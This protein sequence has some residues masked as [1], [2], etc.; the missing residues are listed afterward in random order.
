M[1]G[2]HGIVNGERFRATLV[3]PLSLDHPPFPI[4]TQWCK[5]SC[6]CWL[7]V[8]DSCHPFTMVDERQISQVSLE[9]GDERTGSTLEVASW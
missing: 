3:C 4:R 2:A 9:L 6:R 5:A 1:L 8:M 7:C